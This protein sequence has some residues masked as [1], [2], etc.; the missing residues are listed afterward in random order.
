MQICN[1]KYY[2]YSDNF[3]NNYICFSELEKCREYIPVVDLKICLNS[4]D[5][6]LL[7]NYKIFNQ[8]C[9]SKNCPE[10]TKI[11]DDTLYCSCSYYFYIDS[12][13]INCL[14]ESASCQSYNYLYKNPYTKECFTSL[15]DCII[16]GNIYILYDN[17]YKENCPYGTEIK[18]ENE[19]L[20]Y[21]ICETQ[22]DIQY[23]IPYIIPETGITLS[24][25]PPIDILESICLI[26]Y[27][28]DDYLEEITDN[29]ESIIFNDTLLGDEEIVIFGNNIVYQITTS[30]SVVEY[31]N[32][33]HIDFG[34]CEDILKEKYNISYLLILKYDITINETIPTKVEYNLY[35]PDSKEKLNLSFC[36]NNINIKS[37]L[38][39]DD[40][41]LNLIMQLEKKGLN[42]FNKYDPFY[43]DI[44]LQFRSEY[45]TDMILSDRRQVYYREEQLFCEKGCHFL[46]YDIERKFS[47]K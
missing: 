13:Y 32:V 12:Y 26:N 19:N 27:I 22:Y 30:D 6:C 38:K 24:F 9:Y 5:D 34:E 39:L 43:Y 21:Y 35:S 41:S 7:N 40:N 10:N 47:R 14:P 8:E 44:C 16:K 45:G 31:N 4:I 1:C 3:Y 11:I 42:F 23:D 29:I 36:E 20:S 28:F 46:N 2:K 33:S 18:Y 37:P 25:C 17:C 15:E